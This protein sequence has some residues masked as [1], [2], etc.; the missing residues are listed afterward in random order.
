MMTKILICSV[1]IIVLYAIFFVLSIGKLKTKDD[2]A[3]DDKEQIEYLRKWNNQH[4]L[5]KSYRNHLDEVIDLEEQL[6]C[7]EY[8]EETN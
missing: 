3:F 5:Y 4:N 8:K 1:V 7:V 6:E 2:S